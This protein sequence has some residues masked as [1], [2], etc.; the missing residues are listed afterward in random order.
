MD[1]TNWI[2][3]GVEQ[4]SD[5]DRMSQN[6]IRMNDQQKTDW[7]WH[8]ANRYAALTGDEEHKQEEVLLFVLFVSC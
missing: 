7:H 6:K 5:A 3:T 1:E 2:L 4:K 8:A